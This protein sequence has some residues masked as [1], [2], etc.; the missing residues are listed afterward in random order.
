MMNWLLKL[1]ISAKKSLTSA[2]M[3]CI[4]CSSVPK[5]YHTSRSWWIVDWD[6]EFQK[7]DHQSSFGTDSITGNFL[8]KMSCT[9]PQITQPNLHQIQLSGTVL[10][11]SGRADSETAIDFY[12]WPRFEG[13]IEVSLGDNWKDHCCIIP[14]YDGT[15][16][17]Y[18]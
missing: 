14:Y 7:P 17:I 15:F 16:T 1:N 11:S 3:G 5:T 9:K 13:V 18:F 6:V 10:E 2:C 12:I 4:I 8:F